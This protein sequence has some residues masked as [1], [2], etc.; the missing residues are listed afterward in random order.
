M[1]AEQPLITI[2]DSPYEDELDRYVGEEILGEKPERKPNRLKTT[3]RR[4]KRPLKRII[5]KMNLNTLK[6][7]TTAS[8]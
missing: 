1:A 7:R 6:S 5:R 3:N 8:P 2:A 4:S